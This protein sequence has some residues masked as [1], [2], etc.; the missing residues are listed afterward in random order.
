MAFHV[1]KGPIPP[2]TSDPT[3]RQSIS[4]SVLNLRSTLAAAGAK[5]VRI[6]IHPEG[7]HI[8]W[9]PAGADPDLEPFRSTLVRPSTLAASILQAIADDF[10][11]PVV[12]DAPALASLEI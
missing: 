3:L 5:I 10:E 4:A 7:V 9:L 8:D 2:V 11:I 12:L 6:T 1:V